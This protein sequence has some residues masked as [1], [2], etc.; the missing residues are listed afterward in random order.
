[1]AAELQAYHD[2]CNTSVGA[3]ETPMK[4]WP[5]LPASYAPHTHEAFD[6]AIKCERTEGATAH[7]PGKSL[8]S[9]QGPGGLAGDSDAAYR[10]HTAEST[11][12]CRAYQKDRAAD[13]P[14]M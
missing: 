1:M 3:L 10:V 7:A 2:M 12:D 6:V 11:V 9:L 8:V 4:E 13:H 14:R 5:E